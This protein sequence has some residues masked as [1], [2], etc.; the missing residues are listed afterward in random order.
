MS[1]VVTDV[2]KINKVKTGGDCY[3]ANA[4]FVLDECPDYM[5]CH[6][7]A[8]LK[9]DGLPYGHCWV[10][11]GDVVI[12]KGNGVDAELPLDLYYLLGNIPADGYKIYKYTSKEVIEKIL[13]YG[14]W[15]PWDY[16]PPR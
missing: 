12:D 8:I 10:E 16:K 6:G 15:G 5:L 13:E 7:V 3:E 11:N 9:T 4:R 2:K 1:F 14:H